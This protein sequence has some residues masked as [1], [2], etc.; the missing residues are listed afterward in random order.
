[1]PTCMPPIAKKKARLRQEHDHVEIHRV[2]LE[3]V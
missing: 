3:E 1:M 2:V